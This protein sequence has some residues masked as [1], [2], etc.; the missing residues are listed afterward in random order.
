[1]GALWAPAHPAPSADARRATSK[2]TADTVEDAY[3]CTSTWVASIRKP[4]KI[5]TPKMLEIGP[6]PSSPRAAATAAGVRRS[7][8]PV[9]SDVRGDVRSL[10]PVA[11]LPDLLVDPLARGVKVP[12]NAKYI[13]APMTAITSTA[14][15]A[16]ITPSPACRRGGEGRAADGRRVDV[17][18]R[19][20]LPPCDVEEWPS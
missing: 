7:W 5:A 4:R 11:D 18:M 3:R 13:A 17:E 16:E 1:V 15:A 6:T 2:A 19:H 8:H 14:I 20:F 9:P 12:W 10:L